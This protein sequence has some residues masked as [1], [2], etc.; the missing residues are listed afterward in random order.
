MKTLDI[1][2][3]QVPALGLGTWRL[4]G[5]TCQDVVRTAIEAGYRHIDTAAM[6]G[7]EDDVGI[8]I[9]DAKVPRDQIF[10]VTKVSP[11]QLGGQAL[12]RS[13][14]ASLAKLGTGWI[15][16]L[17]IHWPNRSVRLAESLGAMRDL[18]GEGT[19][20]HIG[21]S[22]F[23]AALMRE[24]IE[25]LGAPIVANQVEY[26]PFLSQNRVLAYCREA[27]V[28]LTA[29]CPLAEGEVSRDP[30]LQRIGAKYNRSAAEVTLNWLMSQDMVSAI[31]MTSDPD[32]LRANLTVLDFQM[33]D[34]DHAAIASLARGRRL[35]DMHTGYGWD[36]D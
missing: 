32:H 35:I 28:T 20:R 25:T 5:R 30:V 36:P 31:P 13:A 14:Q 33:E 4:R 15:D 19:I 29:Y 23:N 3:V 18:V 1:Q 22:N 8:G 6:Y 12:R 24:A 9:A 34:A 7:N 2:G 26:H 11:S 16:M 27:G 17:L 21:V 10:V